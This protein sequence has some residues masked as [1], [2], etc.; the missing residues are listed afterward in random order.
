MEGGRVRG[1][2]AE[3]EKEGLIEREEKKGKR[4]GQILGALGRKFVEL[5]WRMRP[6][7]IR[8]NSWKKRERL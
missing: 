6:I 2:E 5:L 3:G 4:E 7:K 8:E 1:M